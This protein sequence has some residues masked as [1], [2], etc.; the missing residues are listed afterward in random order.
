L[1][2]IPP[3]VGDTKVGASNLV[4]VGLSVCK[5]RNSLVLGLSA[6][7][8]S[9]LGNPDLL[10]SNNI[11]GSSQR[12]VEQALSVRDA[13]CFRVLEVWVCVDSDKAAVADDQ[14]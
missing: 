7:G 4:P 9:S 13:V 2:S 11:F 6:D 12:S 3:S 8:K 14:A 10:A 5:G 1:E